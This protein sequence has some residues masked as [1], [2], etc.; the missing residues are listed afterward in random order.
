MYA[1]SSPLVEVCV[2]DER[3]ATRPPR[4]AQS[5]LPDLGSHA[6][7]LSLPSLHPQPG[8]AEPIE[9]LERYESLGLLGRGGMGSVHRVRDRRLGRT[10]ALKII[11]AQALNRP[12]LVSRF[13]EE[14]QATAQLQHPNIVP[15]YDM[16][17][18]PDGRVWFTMQEVTG[19]TLEQAI[20][21][22]NDVPD[23]HE[24]ARRSGWTLRRLVAA[25]A[26]ICDA[27][28]YA[29]R[30]GVVHRDIKPANIM[31]GAHGEVLVLDW[32]LAKIF[33]RPDSVWTSAATAA[34]SVRT[35][36]GTMSVFQTQAGAV[37]GTPAYM[38]PEQANGDVESIDARTDIY[39]LGALLYELLAGRAPY[40]GHDGLAV[41]EM[42]RAGPPSRLQPPRPAHGTPE[43]GPAPLPRPHHGGRPFP[44]VLVAACERAMA[45]DRNDR[46]ATAG[47]FGEVL[48]EWL[49]GS[50][51]RQDALGVFQT[52]EGLAP[53]AERLRT[54]ARTLR[55][56][57]RAMLDSVPRWA[58]EEDKVAGW[59]K[60]DEADRLDRR[61][62]AL[63]IEEEQLLRGSLAPAPELP[64]AHAALAERCRAEHAALERARHDPSR[65]EAR[66]HQH[67][68]WLSPDDP[69]RI[70]HESYLK[71]DGALTLRTDPPGAT[72]ELFRYVPHR[73]RL[74][75]ESGRELG[76]TPLQAVPLPM[77]SYLCRIH[78]P[79]CE[80][81]D[82]PVAIRRGEHWDGVPPEGG[83]S[84]PVHLPPK[85]SLSS[86]EC[87]VPAG[88]ALLGSGTA[89]GQGPTGRRIWIDGF[90]VR[91]HPITNQEY[92]SFL[93]ALVAAGRTEEAL[94]HAPRE[95]GGHAHS[96]GALIL[97]FDGTRFTLRPDA[98][99]DI[100]EPDYPLTMVDHAGA[101]AAA[102][103][104]ATRTG[105]PWQ[106]PTELQWE[107][108]A[109]GVDGR[110]FPWG[111]GFDPSWAC[112]KESHAERLLPA[113][114]DRFPV[115][116]SP[117]GVRGMGGNSAD[118]CADPSGSDVP[119]PATGRST[120]V[121]DGDAEVAYRMVRGGGWF[122]VEEQVA[123]ANR[124]YLRPNYRGFDLGFRLFRWL[125]D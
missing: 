121:P 15:V 41:L 81:V 104:L 21:R 49:E 1:P 29:H 73:R 90:V 48:R 123:A 19:E 102:A 75:R 116:V 22:R 105:K 111:D 68:S 44:P 10:L 69:V 86:D 118:W 77:G 92:I 85:G 53:E 56:E 101:R 70:D 12:G 96:T 37:A 65:I 52:R 82:Y 3:P 124:R 24:A 93:D 125:T 99:G 25:L 17:E 119:D 32:G 50:Q 107:K 84:R 76:T 14:A 109:R 83:P 13:L 31:L 26:Q 36:R 62:E 63:L 35:A 117:Y 113:T 67:L 20:R 39:A 34:D 45:R 2:S 122:S 42:V 5:T 23:E 115:D 80:P 38:S 108:A 78:H 55:A 103:W 18:M 60:E 57:A 16:G 8:K 61:A 30:R 64:E 97:G 6:D 9:G 43:E 33:D 120:H 72:V 100:W 46:F 40:T 110:R 28:D 98:D 74:A 4:S 27:M 51:R 59:E 71:G 66:L 89:E 112:M 91:R 95:R 7:V 58:P 79:G 88:W 114:I 11:H 106:L 47:A 54:S 87:Y 94:A